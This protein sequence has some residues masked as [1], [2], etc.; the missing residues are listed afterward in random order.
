[1]KKLLIF[2]LLVS[3]FSLLA[4]NE[5]VKELEEKQTL[6][7]SRIV[8]LEDSLKEIKKQINHLKSINIRQ[9]AKDSTLIGVVYKNAKLKE[10]PKPLGELISTLVEGD[11]VFIL[12]YTDHYFGVCSDN[13][14]GYMN[15]MWVKKNDEIWQFIKVKKRE[16]RE[17]E[18]L[19]EEQEDK[20]L[21]EEQAKIDEK[22]RNKYG[23]E[24]FKKL[25]EGYYW[26]EMTK[27][28][29]IISLGYPLEINKTVG[30]W[31]VREQWVYEDMYL[32]FK[33]G[34]LSSY[35]N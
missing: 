6:I 31:G 21:A 9:L 22:Y 25:K 14:C 3:Q 19:K 1:M 32:Y 34:Y 24:I 4:Q 7:E 2:V 10:Q 26:L 33:N 29:A 12:D 16:A 5:N 20:A 18:K 15:E 30:S 35:Q 27:E 11:T 28:M 23:E 17:L 8:L 13:Y